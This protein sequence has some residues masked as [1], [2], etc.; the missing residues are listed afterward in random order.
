MNRFVYLV[1]LEYRDHVQPASA[2][3][4]SADRPPSEK[5]KRL[6]ADLRRYFPDSRVK[7][8]GERVQC[9]PEVIQ[10]TVLTALEEAIADAAFVRFIKERCSRGIRNPLGEPLPAGVASNAFLTAV[11]NCG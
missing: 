2:A 1:Y 11:P 5:A 4:R 8:W 10:I 9:D 7:I 3:S 6:P